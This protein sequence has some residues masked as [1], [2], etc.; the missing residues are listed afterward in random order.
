MILE[1]TQDIA[2]NTQSE[3]VDKIVETRR[4]ST[5]NKKTP[6]MR[7]NDFLWWIRYT[8]WKVL[9]TQNVN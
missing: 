6:I 1:Q 2:D 4:T 3:S 5:R 9:Q 8:A 7:G